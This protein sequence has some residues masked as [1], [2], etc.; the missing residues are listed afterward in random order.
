M[1]RRPGTMIRLD[2]V[3]VNVLTWAAGQISTLKWVE[4]EYA[5]SGIEGSEGK[6]DSMLSAQCERRICAPADV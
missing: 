4:H 1:Y 3:T 6:I 5:D 2:L